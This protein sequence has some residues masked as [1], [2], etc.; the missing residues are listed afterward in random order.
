[1][2][3]IDAKL[4]TVHL[5]LFISF[6]GIL[7]PLKPSRLS[8]QF[9]WKPTSYQLP[10][11]VLFSQS[12]SWSSDLELG[13]YSQDWTV[14]L[15]RLHLVISGIPHWDFSCFS[16]RIWIYSTCNVIFSSHMSQMAFHDYLWAT[17]SSP[18]FLLQSDLDYLL[19]LVDCS[20]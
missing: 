7:K 12:L 8:P 10:V 16:R 11:L 9:L 19:D 1:M 14:V 15:G 2:C 17:E 6:L 5:C 13:R 20:E 4:L 18:I 3:Y